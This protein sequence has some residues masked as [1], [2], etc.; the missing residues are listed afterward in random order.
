MFQWLLEVS[1]SSRKSVYFQVHLDWGITCHDK[2]S[3]GQLCFMTKKKSFSASNCEL[4]LPALLLHGPH[5]IDFNHTSHEASLFQAGDSHCVQL[6]ML[7]HFSPQFLFHLTCVVSDVK[8][9]VHK[10]LLLS[11]PTAELQGLKGFHS[12]LI[13]TWLHTCIPSEKRPS[14]VFLFPAF[15]M[16]TSWFH[17]VVCFW[18]PGT[19]ESCSPF[20]L[21]IFCDTMD[22]TQ[23]VWFEFLVVL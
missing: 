9:Q 20:Q 5:F 11:A 16:L 14:H 1:D 23:Q 22:S 21:K 3:R 12:V 10:H 17:W 19:V 8:T 6:L 2:N 4:F 18:R 13:W 15:P 7:I